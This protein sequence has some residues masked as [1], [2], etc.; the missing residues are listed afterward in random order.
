MPACLVFRPVK[1][2]FFHGV[3]QTNRSNGDAYLD[4]AGRM[5]K[6][7][8]LFLHAGFGFYLTCLKKY[9]MRKAFFAVCATVMLLAAGNPAQA[10]MPDSAAMMKAWMDFATPGPMHRWIAKLNGT[11]DADVTSYM[12]PAAPEKSKATTVYSS[13]FNGLYQEGTMKGTM[14]GMPFEGKSLTGYDNSKKIFFSTWIDNVG[15]GIV[16]MTGTYNEAT[17]TLE[18]KGT[19]TD[20][21]TGKDSGI[22][23]VMKIIDDNTHTMEMYGSSFDGK[24][25]K[26]MEATYKRNMK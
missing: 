7:R 19:Q 9:D 22:R 12:N 1:G 26:F 24:E 2:N 15:S 23:E 13:V 14:F 6:K 25:V 17:K 5:E 4:T 8:N 10:Q 3:E 18:L 11:W 16:V 20:P 21:F